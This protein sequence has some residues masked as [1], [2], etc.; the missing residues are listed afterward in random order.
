MKKTINDILKDNIPANSAVVIAFSGG[1]DSVFLLTKLT[2]LSKTHPLKVIVAHFNHK[3]RGAE[4]NKDEEFSKN[5]AKKYKLTFEKGSY[6]IKKYAKSK[7]LNLEEAA[8]IKRYEFLEKVRAKHNAKA[9]LTAHHLDDNIETFLINFLRGSGIQGLKSMQIM[10]GFILRPLLF[11]PKSEILTFLKRKKIRFR[12]DKSN[13][14][15]SLIRN[16][17]R[18]DLIPILKK[19]QPKLNETFLKIW[20]NLTE[21]NDFLDSQADLWLKK[22]SITKNEIKKTEFNQLHP[23][24]KKRIFQKLYEQTNNT[25][26]GLSKDLL[27]R[28]TSDVANLTTG[29]KAPFGKKNFIVLSRNTLKII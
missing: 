20:E 15:K 6:D 8:R 26:S 10:N 13:F 9:I 14:D 19:F 29:K 25:T 7:K 5:L 22:N 18:H 21:I 16:K 4:S 24:I 12:I 11:T 2:E 27:E 3:L 17:I 1:P 28:L 23:S